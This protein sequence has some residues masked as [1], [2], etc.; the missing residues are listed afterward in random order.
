MLKFFKLTPILA[1]L[2][3]AFCCFFSLASSDEN[4]DEKKIILIDD[5]LAFESIASQA[6]T[7]EEFLNG[8]K[9]E[10]KEKDIIFPE[11]GAKIFS[12]SRIIIERSKNI[13]IISDGRTIESNVVGKNTASALWQN[14]IILGEDDIAE[15]SL[16]HPIRDKDKINVIRVEIK[17]EVVK[18]DV[19]FKTA[20]SK[21]DKLSWRTKKITQKGEKGI[22]EIKYKVVSHDEKE[23][24]RKVIEEKIIKE[25]IAEIVTQGTYVKTGKSHT[26]TATWYSYTGTM[27]AA[28]PWLPLGSYARV[29]NKGNG[30]TVIVRINDRGPFGDGRIIDLDRVAF[31]KIA[32]LGAG[33]IEVKVEEIIN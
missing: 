10:L 30:K 28:S 20:E 33:V 31:E 14:G 29:T 17:E 3:L 19:P 11:K 25:P 9:V 22:K 13:T 4:G 7:V 12:G 18:K 16:E 23:I 15:P 1:S 24:S 6:D 21:D 5:G 32:A 8:Q 27:A 26:G 2:F